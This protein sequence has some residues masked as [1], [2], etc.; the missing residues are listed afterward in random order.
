MEGVASSDR[1]SLP[2]RVLVPV[3]Y[4]SKRLLTIADWFSEVFYAGEG[5]FKGSARRLYVGRGLAVG[6]MVF[7]SFNLFCFLL[8]VYLPRGFKQYY[9]AK[10]KD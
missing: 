4:N 10:V 9:T 8:P 7:W 1:F 3:F 5:E 2:I 6:N